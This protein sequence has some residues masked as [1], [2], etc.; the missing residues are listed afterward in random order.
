M[1][2]KK[3]VFTEKYNKESDM[4]VGR[5][6][7]IKKLNDLYNSDSAELVALYGR[8]R[9]G[10]TFLIDEVFEGRMSF[11]HSGLSPID[12][13]STTDNKRKSKM[14]NQ[15][16]HFFRSLKLQGYK[17][18]EKPK[19]WLEAFY[20][21]EDLIIDKYDDKER[22]LIFI[23][24]I[25]WLDTPRSNF[26]T[27]FEAFWNGWACHKKN[28]MVIVCGSSSSWIL[29]HVIN[30]H[31]GLYGRV[32]YEMKLYPFT[33]KEC[34]LFLDS[35]NICMSRYDMT[36]TYMMVGGIPY[37]LKYFEKELSLPQNID[38]I[39]FSDDAL[40][41]DEYN[42][43]FSSLFVNPEIM[44]TIVGAIGSKT[45]GLTRK[46]LTTQTGISDSGEL[47]KQLK[48]L[49]SGD[50]IIEY[51]SFGNS[52]RETFYKL[53]DPYCNFYLSFMYGNKSNK[54]KNWINIADSPKVTT[55]KGLA[56]E[57]VCWNHIKQIKTALEIGGVSTEESLWSKKGDKDSEGTQIDLII[58]RKDN[59]VNMC[60]SKFYSESFSVD[61][62]YHLILEKRKKLLYE[63]IP[64]KASVHN[65]LITTYG[66]THNEYYGDFV[67][68]V[69]L[70]DLFK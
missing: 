38:N 64:K 1:N 15:L 29:D 36:Q 22:V 69:T 63:V 47:S 2:R 65:I 35:R 3:S 9:V 42:R 40:L 50:F 7:E 37:Y 52:K 43:L 26:M 11:R 44:K 4:I 61:K 30:N 24:E 45:R 62:D 54:R 13:L 46:E 51:N 39:F 23:D 33:L 17:D 31:G 70:D 14:K 20:M 21:L 32:T 18:K 60:E 55:W 58:E 57:N 41:K 49:I 56:F 68:V 67:R 19:S 28:I 66:L 59:V 25:Q 48:A 27:G 10:K 16:D 5:E 53:I 8:R 12:D 6:K 34:E